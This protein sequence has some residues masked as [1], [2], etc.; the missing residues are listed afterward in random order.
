MRSLPALLGSVIIDHCE[1]RYKLRCWLRHSGRRNS[2]PHAAT[3][4][5]ESSYTET[6]CHLFGD[7]GNE[8][9]VQRRA[10]MRQRRMVILVAAALAMVIAL[11]ATACGQDEPSVEPNVEPRA[12]ATSPAAPPAATASPATAV[13]ATVA[14]TP[15]VT[16]LPQPGPS[17]TAPA[18]TAAPTVSPAEPAPTQPPAP[19]PTSTPQSVVSSELQAYADEHAHGPGAIYVGD[20]TQ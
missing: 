6:P 12:E 13:P 17:P 15:A 3:K 1:A 8:S 10:V 5:N 7:L 11:G 16:A 14:P 4:T 2:E 9:T 19:T 20:A 18:T